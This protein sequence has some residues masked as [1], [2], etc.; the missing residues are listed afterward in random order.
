MATKLTSTMPKAEAPIDPR[1]AY[2][3]IGELLRKPGA[4]VALE[5]R[6]AG[7]ELNPEQA[8]LL[9]RLDRLEAA[10]NAQA[11]SERHDPA[12]PLPPMRGPYLPGEA[13]SF[14]KN[15]NA[16]ERRHAAAEY[17]AKVFGN[18]DHAFWHA[19]SHEHRA[20]ALA[21]KIANEIE[22][23]G[24]AYSVQLNPDGSIEDK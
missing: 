19:E 2:Q 11:R 17:R 18:P 4:R 13:M 3:E 20:A 8:R 15:T 5:R 21:M 9:D 23:Y 10:N 14:A 22:V 7:Q 1:S 24:D 6:R 12:P 16:F